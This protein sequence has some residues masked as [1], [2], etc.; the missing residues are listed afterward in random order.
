MSLFSLAFLIFILVTGAVYFAVSREKRWLVL[1]IASYVFYCWGG[2]YRT[3]AFILVTTLLSFGGGIWIENVQKQA[4][5]ALKE[6]GADTKAIRTAA[7]KKKKGILAALLIIIFGILVRVKYGGF[8]FSFL[9]PLFQAAGS[10]FRIHDILLPLGISF[11]TFQTTGYLIDVYRGRAKADRELLKYALFV[12]YFPQII[13]GPISRYSNLAQELYTG[14]DYDFDRV[15]RGLQRLL[16]GYIKKMVIADRVA[17]IVNEVF[18]NWSGVGYVGFTVF[19]GAFL[20]GVQIYADFSG[21]I[22]IILGISEALGIKQVENFRQPYM[23]RSVSEFWQRWHITLGSWMRDYVFY[24]L[25]FSK[26]FGK[27]QKWARKKFGNETGKTV[28]A[29]LASFIVFVLV[30]IWHGAA[31]KFVI[32]GVFQAVFVASGTL[33]ERT[34]AKARNACH[35]DDKKFA[36]R[37][38]QMVR[39]AVILTFG[40]YFARGASLTD[41]LGMWKATFA[42]FNPQVLIDGSFLNLGLS[43]KNYYFMWIMIALMLAVDI[44]HEKGVHI[45]EKIMAR[46]LALRYVLYLLAVFTVIIFGM[47]GPGVDAGMFIYQ[48][49]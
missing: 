19:F 34:Y 46:P 42:T 9:E 22:D 33:L 18:G 4:D 10:G 32:Y 36:W 3:V 7:T 44:A 26:P 24:S 49:F 47:Y 20:Y 23:A 14:H 21:G 45:R 12:S 15:I 28:P 29:C 2:G 37:F 43:V 16:W 27:M 35:I 11:Y 41:A 8:L 40:R 6:E 1:L 17:V 39:T 38:F 30:G 13:Q 25:A 48:G 31:W 5:A